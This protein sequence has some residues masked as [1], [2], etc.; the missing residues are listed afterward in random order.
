MLKLDLMPKSGATPVASREAMELAAPI[1]VASVAYF[2]FF[3]WLGSILVANGQTYVTPLRAPVWGELK[4]WLGRADTGFYLTIIEG[5]YK[6]APYSPN[7]G[8]NWAFFPAY[9]LLVRALKRV[10]VHY[11]PRRGSEA[12]LNCVEIVEHLAIRIVDGAVTFVDDNQIE[13]MWR[14]R[15]GFIVDD[16]EHRRVRSNV[17]SA[18]GGDALF[19]GLRPA[20]LVGDVLFE[21]VE[22]LPTQGDAVNQKQNALHMPRTHEGIDQGDASAGLSGAG[23]HDQKKP[24]AIPLDPFHHR[25]DGLKLEIAASY[26]SVDQL[27]SEGFLVLPNEEQ[28]FEVLPCGEAVDSLR[29]RFA[30]I[31][32][33]D[34]MAGDQIDTPSP[35]HSRV[36]CP[37]LAAR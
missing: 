36:R 23:G 29:R 11:I 3:F 14:E 10:V 33:K 21:S 8:E 32:K 22:R 16:I 7:V 37:D 34:F 35:N 25:T 2:F 31:P 17:D 27:F 30:K 26:S 19:A 5:G 9:P 24:A 1:F 15:G 20:G 4:R 12:E 13:E 28:A 6:A 18:V